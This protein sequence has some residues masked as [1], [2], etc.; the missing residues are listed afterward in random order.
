MLHNPV[1]MSKR[2]SLPEESMKVC[3]YGLLSMLNSFL[4]GSM[5]ANQGIPL[6]IKKTNMAALCITDFDILS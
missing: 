6:K 5:F 1:D 4:T 2:C 3:I